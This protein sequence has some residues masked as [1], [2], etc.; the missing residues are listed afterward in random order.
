[1]LRSRTNSG[2]TASDFH[3]SAP[4]ISLPQHITGEDDLE[5]F[6][7]DFDDVASTQEIVQ[8]TEEPGLDSLRGTFGAIGTIIRA[9]RRARALSAAS[10][11]REEQSTH[12]RSR[13][14][15]E[16][17]VFRSR[18]G[19]GGSTHVR[20]SW[21]PHGAWNT[22]RG[23]RFQAMEIPDV[24]E[25]PDM[26]DISDLE[27]GRVEMRE[28]RTNG[29]LK[30]NGGLSAKGSVGSFPPVF[31]R[32]RTPSPSPAVTATALPGANDESVPATA[33]HSTKSRKSLTESVTPSEKSKTDS[34]EE[35]EDEKG[36]DVQEKDVTEAEE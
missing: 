7:V 20:P 4:R 17:D 9:K 32:S 26:P 28:R 5:D 29:S 12:N 33:P 1:M 16:E 13:G 3:A 21:L 25:I 14:S 36:A 6:D 30:R 24:P 10:H 11:A 22:P 27:K 15:R 35:Q 31:E 34:K 18:S 8:K 23:S 19:S 2:P